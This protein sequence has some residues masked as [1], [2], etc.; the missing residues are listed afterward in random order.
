M[1][2]LQQHMS[3]RR[4]TPLP[5]VVPPCFGLVIKVGRRK[6]KLIVVAVKGAGAEE[7]EVESEEVTALRGNHIAGYI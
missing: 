6:G 7:E 2:F 4:G 1:G 3:W 5:L